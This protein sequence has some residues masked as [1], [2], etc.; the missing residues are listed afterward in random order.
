VLGGNAPTGTETGTHT[1]VGPGTVGGI[2]LGGGGAPVGGGGPTGGVDTGGFQGGVSGGDVLG[3]GV[4]GNA[5]FP[6]L[7]PGVAGAPG[8]ISLDTSGGLLG[9]GNV[10]TNSTPTTPAPGAGGLGADVI[11]HFTQGGGGLMD[12]LIAQIQSG[13]FTQPQAQSILDIVHQEAQQWATILPPGD[14]RW[15]ELMQM[16][17]QRAT[18]QVSVGQPTINLTGGNFGAAA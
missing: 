1:G 4:L 12:N 14:P 13:Q 17:Q 5:G 16:L 10:D 11:P 9:S 3:R 8:G 18:Q 15:T 6:A 7:A 2:S